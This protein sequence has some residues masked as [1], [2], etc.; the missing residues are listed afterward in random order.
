[1]KKLKSRFNKRKYQV[2]TKRHLETNLVKMSVTSLP[3]SVSDVIRVSKVLQHQIE[4]KVQSRR[5]VT[6]RES[7]NRQSDLKLTHRSS[8]TSVRS[9]QNL[10]FYQ[11]S[12]EKAKRML[13]LCLEWS[14]LL[15][16]LSESWES[17]IL[18]MGYQNRAD[19]IFSKELVVP[20]VVVQKN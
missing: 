6:T 16:V 4:F 13:N 12:G 19:K 8:Q 5:K 3:Q 2:I 20:L 10:R 14:L 17:R 7:Q 18:W 11:L 15:Q 9:S 1:M